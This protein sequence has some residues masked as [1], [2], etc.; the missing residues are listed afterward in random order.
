MNLPLIVNPL[1]EADL[2]EAKTYYENQREGLGDEL[3]E[4]VEQALERIR[5]NPCGPAKVYEELRRVLV[6]RFP[7]AVFYRADDDQITVVAIY[8]ARRD[9]RGWQGRA[10]A[11]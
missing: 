9:P 2:T 10:G 4:C 1:A 6:R 3:V 7:Y 8:H 11:P 5:Q